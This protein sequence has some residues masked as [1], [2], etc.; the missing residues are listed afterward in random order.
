MKALVALTALLFIIQP[1]FEQG[2]AYVYTEDKKIELDVELAITIAQRAYGLMY[3]KQLPENSGMIFLYDKDINGS[4]WMQNTYIPLSIAFF[5][6]DG[7]IIYI[8][9]MEPLTTDSHG[10]GRPFRAALEVNKGWFERNNVTVG[11]RT[12]VFRDGKKIFP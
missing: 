3:R 5:D 7:K 11:D 12:E 9:D 4:F 10:P 2:K 8:T 6:A 1:T